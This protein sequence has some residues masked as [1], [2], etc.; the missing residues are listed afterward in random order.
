MRMHHAPALRAR[1]WCARLADGARARKHQARREGLV[2]CH[3]LDGAVWLC[4]SQLGSAQQ[5]VC[6]QQQQQ[7]QGVSRQVRLLMPALRVL[8][9]QCRCL[10]DALLELLLLVAAFSIE[11][12]Q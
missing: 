8:L 7:Q 5:A 1:V 2:V 9:R 3:G 6:R 10:C 12:Y 11:L 4:S